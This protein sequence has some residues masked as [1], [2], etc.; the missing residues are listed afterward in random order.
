MFVPDQEKWTIGMPPEP[1][2]AKWTPAPRVVSTLHYRQDRV[3]FLE[4]GY[5]HLFVVPADGGTPRR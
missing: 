3:G 1:K 4:D 5:T 2:G